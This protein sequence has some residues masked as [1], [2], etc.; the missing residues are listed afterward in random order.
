MVVVVFGFTEY[1]LFFKRY[2]ICGH[3]HHPLVVQGTVSRCGFS[4]VGSSAA[5]ESLLD[6]AL[7]R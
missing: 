6:T 7:D 3:H 5:N 4:L 1:L 2:R